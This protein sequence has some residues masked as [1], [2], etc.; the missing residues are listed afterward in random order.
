MPN[1]HVQRGQEPSPCPPCPPCIH[2]QA[3]GG[4]QPSSA[5]FAGFEG[6]S[7]RRVEL[8][9]PGRIPCLCLGHSWL[10]AGKMKE[11]VLHSAPGFGEGRQF[12]LIKNVIHGPLR[13][14]C[15]HGKV[16]P[17]CILPMQIL[18]RFSALWNINILWIPWVSSL[19]I[20]RQ[21]WQPYFTLYLLFVW[22]S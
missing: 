4:S 13:C 6:C 18:A 5:R 9:L 14:S 15:P 22:S 21:P 17:G 8:L 19:N 3:P 20:L 10:L 11:K 12:C 2:S 7:P 1:P 16:H